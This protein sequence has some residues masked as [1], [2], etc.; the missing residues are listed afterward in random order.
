ME[1]R[2]PQPYRILQIFRGPLVNGNKWDDLCYHLSQD[3]SDQQSE[4]CCHSV[5]NL[6]INTDADRYSMNDY[7]KHRITFF[8]LTGEAAQADL[9]EMISLM[10]EHFFQPEVNSLVSRAP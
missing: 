5:A 8:S 4:R 2:R 7:N 1:I 6:R 10:I 9:D 3:T